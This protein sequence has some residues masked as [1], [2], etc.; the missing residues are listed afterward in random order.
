MVNKNNYLSFVIPGE[1]KLQIKEIQDKILSIDNKFK[2]IALDTLHMTISFF[3][4]NMSRFSKIEV[5]K[6]MSDIDDIIRNWKHNIRLY[7][8]K[9]INFPPGKNNLY[10]ILYTVDNNGRDLVK[11]INERLN[12]LLV[13]Q[14]KEEWIPHITIGKMRDVSKYQSIDNN[15]G[16]FYPSHIQLS[17]QRYS[18]ETWKLSE[19]NG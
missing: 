1:I 5:D 8:P 2:P 14:D 6:F 18:N 11:I 17:G 10:I 15:L 16:D 4:E 9:V 7:N 3:G 13:H 12:H 19:L